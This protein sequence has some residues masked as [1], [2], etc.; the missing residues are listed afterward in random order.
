[1]RKVVLTGSELR[2]QIEGLLDSVYCVNANTTLE[3]FLYGVMENL[4]V[5]SN[6]EGI[7]Y[8]KEEAE[9]VAEE[10]YYEFVE[11]WLKKLEEQEEGVM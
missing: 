10:V 11:P 3:S 2:A 6:D 4:E 7:E 8:D 5:L 1:M 9:R